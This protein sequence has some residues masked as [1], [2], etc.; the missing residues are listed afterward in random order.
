[1]LRFAPAAAEHATAL[2]AHREAVAQYARALRFGL[3]LA[4]EARA[5]LLQAFAE[6]SYLTDMRAEG[7]EMLN[8]ALAIHANAAT[9]SAGGDA[10]PRARLHSCIGNTAESEVDIDAALEALAGEPPGPE[11]A[12]VYSDLAGAAMQADDVVNAVEGAP[13]RLRWPS[14][15]TRSTRWSARSTTSEARS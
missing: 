5:D 7:I 9:P 14:A 15:A 8:E 6:A 3:G 11:L 1:M 12:E 13:A 4:P 2:G 10:A